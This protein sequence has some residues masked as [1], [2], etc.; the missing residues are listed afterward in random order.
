MIQYL[1]RNIATAIAVS[2][3]L[4]L[5][6]MAIL[7]DYSTQ[8]LIKFGLLLSQGL[9]L[10]YLCFRFGVLGQNSSLPLVLFSILSVLIAPLLSLGDLVYGVIW[11][12]AFFFA[13]ESGE[14]PHKSRNYIIYFGVLLGVAQTINNISVLLLIPVFMLFIQTGARS[15]RDFV[16]SISY[17]VM[18]VMSF[19]GVLYVMELQDKLFQLIPQ[20]TFDYSTF[21]NIMIKLLLPFVFASLVVHYLKLNGYKFRYPNQTKIL[22]YTMLIQLAIAVALILLT[23]DANF[24][25]Y[26]VMPVV[27]VLSFMFLYTSKS[28]FSNAAF[29]SLICIALASLWMYKIL[30]L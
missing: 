16:L 30:I 17:F 25:I 5:S 9:I 8:S 23:A 1:T 29:L 4:F 10:N 26:F 14:N 28:I 22:N 19:V 2:A 15:L 11:L 20:L 18:V 24:L 12:A 7:G 6:Y 13:F 21:N 27:V 3:V